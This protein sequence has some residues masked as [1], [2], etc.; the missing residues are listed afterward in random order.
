M[1]W[2]VHP[3]SELRTALVHAVRAAGMEVAEAARRL[4]V[5]RKT[6]FKWLARHD[7]EPDRPLTDRPRRPLRS[8][9][10]TPEAAERAVLE[11]RDRYGWG[12]RKL[13]ALLARDGQDPPPVRTIAAILR[14]HGRVAAPPAAAAAPPQRFERPAPNELWQLDFKGPIEVDRRRVA[15]LVVLDDHS[16]YLLALRPCTDQTF[17]TVQAALW[18]IFGDVGLPEAILCDNAF[19]A[20]VSGVG[21]SAFDGWLV[22]LGI[23]PV[24]GRA[25]HPQTQGKVER[26]NGT[27]ERELWPRARRDSLEHFAA[28]CEAFRPLY[29]AVRPHEALDDRPPV[30]RWVPSPRRRPDRA[31]EAAYPSGSV[32]R[33]VG[34][35]G[36]VRYRMARITVG[37]GLAGEP[38]R[39]HECDGRVEVYYCD[40][41]V[42]CLSAAD[43][44]RGTVL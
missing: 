33:R 24:H 9:R 31:P 1:P 35:T 21:L 18:E 41:R 32:V 25:Y 26:L 2:E 14:R 27:L 42:R 6:A 37:R 17:A 44:T 3:V 38:V 5:S 4:G 34:D 28:D 13:H 20:R 39:V 7:A 12:P 16:R 22:R 40:Y 19:S 10:R 15:P 8:P 11:A 29:N 30:T 36:R 23:R 43:L